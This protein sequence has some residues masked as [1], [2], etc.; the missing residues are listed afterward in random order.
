MLFFLALKNSPDPG[1]LFSR[2]LRIRILAYCLFC[3][4]TVCPQACCEMAGMLSELQLFSQLAEQNLLAAATTTALA[5]GNN[6]SEQHPPG[7]ISKSAKKRLRAIHQSVKRVQQMNDGCKGGGECVL[8]QGSAA[9]LQHEIVFL[10]R[11][12][13][14]NRGTAAE[15][16]SLVSCQRS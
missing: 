4:V 5:E 6:S 12:L 8:D 13:D 3:L 9:V 2:C 7:V 1:G 16:S 14:A 10:T 11:V 15:F